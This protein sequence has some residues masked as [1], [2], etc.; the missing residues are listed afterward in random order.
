MIW[1]SPQQV[2]LGSIVLDHVTMLSIDRSPHKTALQWTDLG[3]HLGFAD[4]PEQRVDVR[5]EREIIESESV[6]LKP[7]DEVTLIARRAP[8][9]SAAGVVQ[10]S[11]TVVILSIDHTLSKSRGARQRIH[12]IAISAGGLSDPITVQ[13]V[14]GEI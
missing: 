9:A 11:A 8:G 7:G 2:S 10:I 13:D 5:I 12:A 6:D 1:L 4:V 3:P 14:E